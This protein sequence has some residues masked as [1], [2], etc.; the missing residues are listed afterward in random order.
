MKILI[1]GINFH[2]EP[3]G[4]GKY[5]GEMAASL[6][7]MGHEVRFIT[8]P[9]YYPAWQ[10]YKGWRNAYGITH[11][12]GVEVWR[13]PLWVP[14]QPSGLKRLMHL[15][16]FSM[17][18]IPLLA[19][20]LFWR[21]DV[22]MVVAPA[23][24][25]APWGWLTARLSGAQ[26]WLHVQD[27]EVDAAFE[28]GM[29]KDGGLIRRMVT[30]VEEWL[31]RR[32]DRVSTISSRMLERA[33]QKGVQ[34]KR[35]VFLPNWVD[36]QTIKPLQGPSPYRAE[37]GIANDAV[38][39]L[40]SGTLNGKQ[41]LEMLP[42]VARLLAN[43]PDF[44]LVI[45]GDGVMKP[46]LAQA[47]VGLERV[48]LLPLQP[49]ERVND[50]LGMADIHLL[51]QNPGAADLVMPSK[52]T[53]MLASGR[54]V[55]TTAQTGTELAQVVAGCGLVVEPG[56]RQQMADAIR[57]LLDAPAFRRELG[58]AARRHAEQHLARQA[59]M[60]RLETCLQACVNDNLS[61]VELQGSSAQP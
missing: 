56:N 49:A 52:L 18:S 16:S 40:F 11:W 53:G 14:E 36:D 17:A 13:A 54:P 4:I 31:L 58:R 59:V 23:L 39:A 32:Y 27:F 43:R 61:G 8:A 19:R 9:P 1:H 29:L 35:Q 3:T 57:Q 12:K 5:S 60:L 26:A 34:T 46:V 37:L 21:P 44:H 38:V 33:M 48:H 42:D 22:V 20:Q 45:C 15:F 47:C 25:C 51:P 50:L 30:G 2:P 41:G 7:A 28:L 6:A 55:V 24:A 10:I